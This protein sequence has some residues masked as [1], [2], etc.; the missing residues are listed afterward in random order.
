MQKT[1][2]IIKPDAVQRRLI[3]CIIKR[4]EEKGLQIMGLKM[5]RIPETLAIQHY[6]AHKGK[7]FY[8]PLIRYTTSGPVVLMVLKG[9]NA[10]EVARKMMGATFGADA[11]PGTIRG[12]YAVSNRFNLI[13]GSDSEASAEKEINTFFTMEE[14]AEYEAMD[15]SW[16]YDMSTGTI[17]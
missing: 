12:D 14:L 1:L 3:G 7:D 5:T 11:L 13:H 2:I 15:L 17:V 4:F 16:I 6:S 9:K 10:I 8:E